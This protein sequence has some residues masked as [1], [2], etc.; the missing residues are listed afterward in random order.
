M[1]SEGVPGNVDGPCTNI[2]E[3]M[4]FYAPR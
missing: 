4:M 2:A 3:C 1:Q